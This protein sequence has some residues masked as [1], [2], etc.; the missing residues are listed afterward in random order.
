LRRIAE[1]NATVESRVKNLADELTRRYWVNTAAVLAVFVAVFALITE[2]AET[3]SATTGGSAWD[4]L[5][6]NTA[7]LAPLAV[8]LLG[9][10]FALWVFLRRL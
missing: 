1:Y 4:I 6:R 8:V 7:A 5:W 2:G 9:F 10:V 3:V